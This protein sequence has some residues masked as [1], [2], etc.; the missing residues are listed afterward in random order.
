MIKNT[1]RNV[2]LVKKVRLTY[3]IV[4]NQQRQ[5]VKEGKGV[6]GYLIISAKIKNLSCVYRRK[7]EIPRKVTVFRKRSEVR[8]SNNNL[9]VLLL[10]RSL[11]R[12]IPKTN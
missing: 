10:N 6:K 3:I 1:K 12:R 7:Y 5:L 11:L 2:S 4:S 9:S 8:K